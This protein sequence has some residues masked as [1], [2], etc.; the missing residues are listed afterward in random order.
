MNMKRYESILVLMAVVL[1][2]AGCAT[3]PRWSRYEVCFGLSANAGQ[4]RVSDLQWQ[5]FRDEEIVGRF[6]DG[7]TLYQA[8]GYW[9]SGSVT[10]GEPSEILVVVAPD[11]QATRQK[12]DAI[13]SAYA[14]RFQQE[15]VLQIKSR[16]DVEFHSAGEQGPG[17]GERRPG[18]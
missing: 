8:N 14:R 13:A 1:L 7:F 11:T 6:P 10:Y 15:S 12:L 18:P 17:S 2:A 3:Q 5:Q 9:R 4:T 16:V